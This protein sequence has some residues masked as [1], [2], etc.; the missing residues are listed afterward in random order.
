VSVLNKDDSIVIGGAGGFI[1]GSLARYF[2]NQRFTRIRAIDK[3]IATPINLGSNELV[4]LATM[5][6]A[7][8]NSHGAALYRLQPMS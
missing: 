7:T 4:S 8:V 6:S 3:L 2:H 1:A 5:I